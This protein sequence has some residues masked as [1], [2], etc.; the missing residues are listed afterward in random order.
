MKK[1]IVS[2]LVLLL[3]AGAAFVYM[4]YFYVED[5][6]D[7]FLRT[8]SAAMLGDEEA[9]LGGFTPDS[10]PLIAGLL[11]LS[12]GDD[13]R[14]STRHPYHHLVTENVESTEVDGDRAWVRVR[15]MGA[16]AK[17]PYDIPLVRDGNSWKIDALAFTGKV[18]V[19]AN[20]R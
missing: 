2:I 12:R 14:T 4:K 18:H 17:P 3:L 9:F 15:P 16:A 20:A 5:P 8:A 7:A 10:K 6:R 19:P 1:L 13:V 11:S